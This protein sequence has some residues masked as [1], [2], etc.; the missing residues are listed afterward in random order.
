MILW[1]VGKQRQLRPV[2]AGVKPRKERE[3]SNAM[4]ISKAER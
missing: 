2:G 1:E 4:A 3:L